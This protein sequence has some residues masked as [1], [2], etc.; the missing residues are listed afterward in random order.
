VGLPQES[1]NPDMTREARAIFDSI[2][3]RSDK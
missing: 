2:V 1:I 3:F